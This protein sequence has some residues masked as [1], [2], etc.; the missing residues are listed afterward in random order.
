MPDAC[1]QVQKRPFC[2]AVFAAHMN[3]HYNHATQHDWSIYLDYTPA[4]NE[5]Q[6]ALGCLLMQISV[7]RDAVINEAVV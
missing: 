6:N 7:Y 3:H 4:T 1:M 5:T 2:S